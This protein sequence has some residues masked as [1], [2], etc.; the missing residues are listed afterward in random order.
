VNP[1]YIEIKNK[2]AIHVGPKVVYYGYD[3]LAKKSKLKWNYIRNNMTFSNYH[4]KAD[5]SS[6]LR[7]Y[8]LYKIGLGETSGVNRYNIDDVRVWNE[9][10]WNRM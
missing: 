5:C 9:S 7:Y 6:D 3:A 2:K 10:I 1:R 8:Y 4:K